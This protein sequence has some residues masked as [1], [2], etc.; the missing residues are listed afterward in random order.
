MEGRTDLPSPWMPKSREPYLHSGHTFVTRARM[1]ELE[2]G[3]VPQVVQPELVAFTHSSLPHMAV[4]Y[5]ALL[6]A[7]L[8]GVL[9]P[10]CKLSR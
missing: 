2:I 10:G 1:Y 5:C 9:L 7:T 6:R 3:V 4:L 8:M